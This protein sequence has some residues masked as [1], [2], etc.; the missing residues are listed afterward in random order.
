MKCYV[1]GQ[2]GVDRESNGIYIMCVMGLCTEHMIRDDV[3]VWEVG[4]PFPEKKLKK[5]VL[6]ILCP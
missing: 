6:R 4:Y 1:C 3:S 5:Q 2:L